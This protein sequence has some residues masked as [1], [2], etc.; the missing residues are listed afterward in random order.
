MHGQLPTLESII[1]AP[2]FSL[3]FWGGVA[4]LDGA[5]KLFLGCPP[6][7]GLGHDYLGRGFKTSRAGPRGF[8]MGCRGAIRRGFKMRSPGA[9]R[10]NRGAQGAQENRLNPL[11]VSP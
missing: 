9:R 1:K 3:F 11:P 10:F 2:S 7:V 5:S 4:V 8:R 6:G